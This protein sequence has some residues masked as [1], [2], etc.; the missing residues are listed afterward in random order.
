M[1]AVSSS[2]CTSKTPSVSSKLASKTGSCNLYS[3]LVICC[4]FNIYKNLQK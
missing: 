4:S 2:T 1:F 3:N